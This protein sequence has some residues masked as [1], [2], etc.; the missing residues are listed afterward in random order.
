MTENS[1]GI[2][3]VTRE[4]VQARAVELA[5]INGHSAQDVSKSDWEQARRELTG[6]P[7]EDPRQAILDSLPETEL[8]DPTPGS[9]ATKYRWLRARMRMKK[10]EAMASGSSKR[11]CGKRST[12]KCSRLRGPNRRRMNPKEAVNPI[13]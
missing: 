12:T 6:E 4:M 11:E 7:D 5:E 8:W 3:T 13:D 10:G 1:A 9:P 2:G